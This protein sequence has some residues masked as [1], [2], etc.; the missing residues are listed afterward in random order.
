MRSGVN[1]STSFQGTMRISLIA[2][3]FALSVFGQTGP[4]FDVATI[5]PAPPDAVGQRIGLAGAGRINIENMALADL[6][7]FAY[8]EGLAVNLE[9]RGGPPW[10]TKERYNIQAQGDTDATVPKMK[11]M[12]RALLA[13]RFALKTHVEQKEVDVYSLVFAKRGQEIGS[14]SEGMGRDLRRASGPAGRSRSKDAALFGDVQPHGSQNGGHDH[15]GGGGHAVGAGD[16][17]WAASGGPDGVN[18]GV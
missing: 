11:L 13:E 12:T 3:L 9:I 8:G 2:A 1:T 10:V 5:K 16:R 15:G 18:C 14:Q 6:I 4:S 17:D 7:K